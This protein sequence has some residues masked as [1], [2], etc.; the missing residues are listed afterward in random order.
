MRT[1]TCYVDDSFSCNCTCC[2]HA[3]GSERTSTESMMSSGMSMPLGQTYSARIRSRPNTWSNKG[4][5][6]VVKLGKPIKAAKIEIARLRVLG[7]DSWQSWRQTSNLFWSPICRRRRR[8]FRSRGKWIC[9]KA[10]QIYFW[11]FAFT[12][13]TD[14]WGLNMIASTRWKSTSKCPSP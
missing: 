3:F 6:F 1:A 11:F 10:G 4:P 2:W 14:N 13:H 5:S 12:I 8:V 7:M 9:Y